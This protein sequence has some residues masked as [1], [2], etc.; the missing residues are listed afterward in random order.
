MNV[1][2]QL[3]ALTGWQ[4]PVLAVLIVV[5][6]SLAAIA[7]YLLYLAVK[8]PTPKAKPAEQPVAAS[9]EA[10]APAP[11]EAPA[12]PSEA[13]AEEVSEAPT[14]EVS[15]PVAVEETP[16][17]TPE[18]VPEPAAETAEEGTEP[19]TPE[20]AEPAAVETSETEPEAEP[21]AEEPSEEAAEAYAEESVAAETVTEP[22]ESSEEVAEETPEETPEAEVVVAE[23]EPETEPEPVPEEP[24]EEET[25]A[26]PIVAETEPEEEPEEGPVPEPVSEAP[27]ASLK[28]DRAAPEESEA[29]TVQQILEEHGLTSAA[30]ITEEIAEEIMAVSSRRDEEAKE[31]VCV[32]G[33]Y[34]KYSKKADYAVADVNFR[35]YEGEIVGL[36]GHNG[37][38]KSTTLKCLEGMLPFDKG[39]ISIFGHDIV[40]DP[41]NAK[42]N[43]GFVTDNHAT[44]I[45]MT[46]M[47]Y[48]A[49]MADVYG[50]PTEERKARLE[51]LESVF[52][53][54]EAI[55]NLISSYSHGMRQK[56]CM[57]G[58]LIHM[59]KLWVLDEPMT[60]LDPRTMHAV[61]G[62]MREYADAGNCIIFSSH[63]LITV[64]KMCDRVVLLR[65]GHQLDE[66]N[67][68]RIMT[69]D[70]NF[71]FEEYF[72]RHEGQD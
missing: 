25:S 22:A 8:A 24:A 41:L 1:K 51:K 64:A 58:S 34:K 23:T 57:M 27:A 43:M 72:L 63:A 54:G 17:E 71:D 50:V 56:I 35:C 32:Q 9:R 62:F 39:N 66:L 5:A 36:L 2:L 30:Q 6:A 20:E 45:K 53:L 4:I 42:A 52:Q 69:V 19:E 26:E 47:Q 18:E 44:F 46:G 14:E 3:L 21:V 13:P 49:F 70:P 37:A 67:I 16:E 33:L 48:L 40:K 29:E 31:V 68:K 10:V 60:G 65:T 12:E 38:G 55:D 61:Q 28:E 15:E 59:P 7:G 11:E